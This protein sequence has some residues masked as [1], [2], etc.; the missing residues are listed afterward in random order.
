LEEK[1]LGMEASLAG[2]DVEEALRETKEKH[3]AVR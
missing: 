2:G 3:V 1:Y